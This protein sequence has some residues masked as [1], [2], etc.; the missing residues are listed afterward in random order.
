MSPGRTPKRVALTV[1]SSWRGRK[2]PARQ[3]QRGL[4]GPALLRKPCVSTM[5][6]SSLIPFAIVL[7]RIRSI[8]VASIA[9]TIIC[10]WYHC[11]STTATATAAAATTTTT[12]PA[13]T[14]T[15][16]TATTTT[17]SDKNYDHFYENYCYY[18]YYYY[19]II[20]ISSSSS[21][22]GLTAVILATIAINIS[23]RSQL[24][25]TKSSCHLFPNFPAMRASSLLSRREKTPTPNCRL[26]KGAAGQQMLS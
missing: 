9:I 18:Y 1:L 3:I 13:T 8:R 10:Y 6:I 4:V 21:S 11:C 19:Y 26:C 7:V 17:A 25:N 22:S 15:T 5:I 14:T 12:P 16:T 20:I 2:L 23:K 24:Q